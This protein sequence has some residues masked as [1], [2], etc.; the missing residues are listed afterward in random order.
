MALPQFLRGTAP[1]SWSLWHQHAE[2]GPWTRVVCTHSRSGLREEVA[3]GPGGW[4]V[5]AMPGDV[6]RAVLPGSRA[7][8]YFGLADDGVLR[9]PAWTPWAHSQD[10]FDW[11]QALRPRGDWIWRRAWALCPD[12][13][14]MLRA[15]APHAGRRATARLLSDLL[16]EDLDAVGLDPEAARATQAGLMIE[17]VRT[18]ADGEALDG[19]TLDAMGAVQRDLSGEPPGYGARRDHDAVG[20]LVLDPTPARSLSLH[21][22]AQAADRLGQVVTRP[23]E[24][25]E[26]YARVAGGMGEYLT[27]FDGEWRQTGRD[28]D[29]DHW[30][31]LRARLADRVRARVPFRDL[32][33]ALARAP[34]PIR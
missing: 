3:A 33:R 30:A 5:A 15:L 7:P 1:E 29:P 32:V 28:A 12:G 19:A 31:A 23:A 11:S 24:G 4:P 20:R 26:G 21:L 9:S 8:V 18:W 17:A 25:P 22:L 13:R 14:W 6:V 2:G 27:Q 10:A 34:G 16:A